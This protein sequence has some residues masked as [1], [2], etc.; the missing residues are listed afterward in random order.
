MKLLR[1]SN[2]Q[3]RARRVH[4]IM[5]ALFSIARPHSHVV[6]PSKY[7]HFRL[8]SLLHVNPVCS[9]FRY[10]HVV[11]GPSYSLAILSLKLTVTL[12]GVVCNL[13]CH[14]LQRQT[15]GEL[16]KTQRVISYNK[17]CDECVILSKT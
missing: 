9:R 13:L 5:C 17:S 3:G 2:E 6:S 4:C 7:P 1:S 11:H 8:C 10:L 15:L 16:Y 14:S 12:S